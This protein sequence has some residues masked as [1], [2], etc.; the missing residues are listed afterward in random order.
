V[1]E[2]RKFKVESGS[3]ENKLSLNLL[4]TLEFSKVLS[5]IVDQEMELSMSELSELEAA[6]MVKVRE[7]PDR[8]DDL[9]RIKQ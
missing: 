5:T 2:S 8:K 9:M 1:P 6:I 3:V 7:C 4:T